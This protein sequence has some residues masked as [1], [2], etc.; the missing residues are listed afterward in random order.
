MMKR[1]LSIICLILLVAGCNSKNFTETS[2]SEV[3]IEDAKVFLE[4]L[5]NIKEFHAEVEYQ[6]LMREHYGDTGI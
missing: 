1:L 3:S 6:K 5:R 4:W 2:S